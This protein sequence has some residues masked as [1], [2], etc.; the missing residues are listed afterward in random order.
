MNIDALEAA[1]AA[2]AGWFYTLTDGRQPIYAT[3]IDRLFALPKVADLL[4]AVRER[5]ALRAAVE[6]LAADAGRRDYM[7]QEVRAGA[8]IMADRLRALLATGDHSR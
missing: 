4:A 5:D 6:G 1:R 3:D 2:V 8:L 7:T